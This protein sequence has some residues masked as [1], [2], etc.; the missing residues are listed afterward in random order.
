DVI[1]A[2]V[3]PAGV[4]WVAADVD[5]CIAA[6][7]VAAGIATDVDT[8]SAMARLGR[9]RGRQPVER[10]GDGEEGN[11]DKGLALPD[12]SFPPVSRLG[13]D[14]SHCIYSISSSSAPPHSLVLGVKRAAP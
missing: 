3:A 4:G 14:Q 7:V 9:R 5:A 10:G 11:S 6:P 2:R 1:A 13:D 12:H 8:G